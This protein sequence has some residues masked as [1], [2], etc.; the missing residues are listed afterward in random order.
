M[1]APGSGAYVRG[2]LMS[3]SQQRGPGFNEYDLAG[4]SNVPFPD[5]AQKR[6]APGFSSAS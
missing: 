6:C 2:F 1:C 3:T 5:C 4:T